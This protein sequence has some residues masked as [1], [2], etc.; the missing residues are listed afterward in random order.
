MVRYERSKK[1]LP[2]VTH[3]VQTPKRKLWIMVTNAG[4]DG[5]HKVALRAGRAQDLVVVVRNGENQADP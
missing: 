2:H 4:A 5:W 3:D 1:T